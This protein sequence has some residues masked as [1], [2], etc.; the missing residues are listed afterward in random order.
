MLKFKNLKIRQKLEAVFFVIVVS[1][2]ILAMIA[3][4][5][6]KKII[7]KMEDFYNQ[8]HQAEVLIS[9]AVIYMKQGEKNL[10][11]ADVT[12]DE[13]EVQTRLARA[14]ES[15]RKMFDRIDQLNKLV[16][17]T[18][19]TFDNIE[20]FQASFKKTIDPYNRISEL[21]A[22]GQLTEAMLLYDDVYEPLLRES[23]DAL[24]EMYAKAKQQS[25]DYMVAAQKYNAGTQNWI[26]GQSAVTLIILVSLC[27]L[28][29]RSLVLPIRQIEEAAKKLSEG[30]LDVDLKYHGKDELGRLADS[31][32]TTI[33]SLGT[34]IGD[35]S[36]CLEQMADG[37]FTIGSEHGETYKGELV[38]ILESMRQ[39]KRRM[40]ETLSQINAAASQVNLGASQVSSG[41]QVLSQGSTEQASSIQELAAAIHQISVQVKTNTENGITAEEKANGVGSDVQNSNQKMQEMIHAMDVI[42]STS[43]E[44]SKIIKT[45]EDIAFQTNILALNAAV[46]A[47]RAGAA[48][49]G[50]AVVADEVR[51]LA[52]KSA[53][54]SKNTAALIQRSVDAVANGTQIVN[55]TADSLV[56]TV[57][58]V[59]EVV[60]LVNEIVDASKEQS[61]AIE[62]ISAG[63]DQISA[64]VET[65]SATSEESAASSE[66]LASQAQ[67]MRNLV[68][69]FRL[70]NNAAPM[71]QTAK[72]AEDAEGL[73]SSLFE[74]DL[75]KY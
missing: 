17:E 75:S 35:V 32:R 66:E 18:E 25:A 51:N 67:L 3:V 5:N 53:E 56:H 16:K 27:I 37:N 46:E 45:I 36:N 6:G 64:V 43:D 15:Y 22:Q 26:I 11:W 44:I 28:L 34:V 42:N 30:Q 29:V 21:I 61:L 13:N 38:K 52:S 74:E 4:D 20:A 59:E 2:L 63:I 49:K 54:A 57:S 58:G 8:S 10:L 19:L 47:A 72:Y 60:S 7:E 65:N 55:D 48:G 9:D 70:D 68:G 1:F 12:T 71:L 31:V 73:G 41:A 33:S 23:E 69:K 14:E 62:Q 40:N 24:I 39:I 50:F